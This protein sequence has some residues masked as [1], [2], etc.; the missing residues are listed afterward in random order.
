MRHFIYNKLGQPIIHKGQ[1]NK[2][3]MI[4]DTSYGR[5]CLKV[6]ELNGDIGS[7]KYSM[8]VFPIAFKKGR[9][10]VIE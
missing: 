3:D 9:G 4:S 8:G 2:G 10:W 6:I 7:V 1:L 5:A